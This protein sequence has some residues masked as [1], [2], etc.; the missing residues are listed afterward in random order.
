M[1]L[2]WILYGWMIGFAVF[3]VVTL[4]DARAKFYSQFGVAV[5][6]LTLALIA[7]L[8]GTFVD[9]DMINYLSW[10]SW[11]DR[12][13]ESQVE[14]VRDPIFALSAIS[15]V[16]TNLP[17]SF[18]FLI[19]A[20]ASTMTKWIFLR[21]SRYTALTGLFLYLFFCRFYFLHDMTQ[22]RAGLGIAL[23]SLAI[24]LLCQR[25]FGLG[26]GLFALGIGVHLVASLMLPIAFVALSR[27][28]LGARWPL[29]SMLIISILLSFRIDSIISAVGLYNFSRTS[30]YL[31][32]SYEV[33]A[34]TLFSV[35]FIV[36]SA[37][38]GLIILLYWDVL[39]KLERTI[40]YAVVLG[41]C[42]QI[43]FLNLDVFSLRS[44]E[45][46]AMFDVLMLLIPILRMSQM[47]S[48]TYC[49]TIISL[50]FVF[51]V[52]ALDIMQPYRLTN[53]W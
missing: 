27:A 51:F 16:R 47:L 33:N 53:F 8:R 7:G 39:S 31:D 22:I 34:N 41:I 18:Y 21:I 42:L 5:T 20:I 15:F 30:N 32:G 43:S 44:S 9:P 46:F 29:A 26:F 38:A 52:S 4:G 28:Q 50:G 36:R 49:F 14:S 17:I 10:F 11:L 2:Y 37:V 40:L 48:L 35:Y 12:T 3:N 23:S 19:I 6:L 24:V 45:V 1:T 13:Y 25:R